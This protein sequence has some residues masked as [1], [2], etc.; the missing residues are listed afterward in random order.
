[1]PLLKIEGVSPLVDGSYEFDIGTFTNREMHVIK[2]ISGVRGGEIGE[3]LAAGDN[4]IVV[5]LTA[6]VLKRN[7]KTVPVDVLWDAELGK[8]T[9]DAADEEEDEDRPPV[10]S[11]TPSGVER[12]P[13][14]PGSPSVSSP[15]SGTDSGGSGGHLV[16]LQSPT[17]G[18][19][20]ETAAESDQAISA[21]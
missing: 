16:N 4:D 12:K 11:P 3:A 13:D 21:S 6:I 14:E 17:G 18:P 7:G 5:A 20:S 2:E 15:S 9:L 10:P 19:G 1:M 8:I